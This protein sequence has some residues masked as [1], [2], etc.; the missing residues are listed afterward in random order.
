MFD[1]FAGLP[2]V[3]TSKLSTVDAGTD[4]VPT[5][6]LPVRPEFAFIDGN[7]PMSRLERC[8]LLRRGGGGPRRDRFP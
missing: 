1:L 4:T 7:T 8:P 3:S 2:D 6:V 5:S